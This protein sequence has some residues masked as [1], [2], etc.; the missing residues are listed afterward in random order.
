MPQRLLTH[1]HMALRNNTEW[2]RGHEVVVCIK[3]VVL[4]VYLMTEGGELLATDW[5]WQPF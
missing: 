1:S 3:S 5:R 4:K 2:G